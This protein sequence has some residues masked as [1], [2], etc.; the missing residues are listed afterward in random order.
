MAGILPKG[1]SRLEDATQR[2]NAVF[3]G[4]EMSADELDRLTE[5]LNGLRSRA[6]DPVAR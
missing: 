5:L 6:G 2:I 3:E 4:L 1:R